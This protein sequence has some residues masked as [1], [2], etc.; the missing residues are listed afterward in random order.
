MQH[1][2][3]RRVMVNIKRKTVLPLHLIAVGLGLCGV[4][5]FR[6]GDVGM[7]GALSSVALIMQATQ[8]K[9]TDP[10]W[11]HIRPSV[12]DVILSQLRHVHE[13]VTVSV[14]LHL[15]VLKVKESGC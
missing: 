6:G 4:E 13:S 10:S 11:R 3:N 1:Q 14:M 2:G 8:Q 5:R 7:L 15:S 9:L 12:H